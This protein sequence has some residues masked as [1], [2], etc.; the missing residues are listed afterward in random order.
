LGPE[1]IPVRFTNGFA[2]VEAIARAEDV[3]LEAARLRVLRRGDLLHAKLRAATDST[4]RRSKRL[5]DLAD[6]QALLESTPTLVEEL[7][8]TARAF[9]EQLPC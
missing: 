5:Q 1:G 2:L 7:S 4:R 3:E 8:T 6:A 9:L